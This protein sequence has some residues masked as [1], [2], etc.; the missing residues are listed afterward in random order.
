MAQ[1]LAGNA[2]G[3]FFVKPELEV[4][5]RIEWALPFGQKPSLPVG[6]L[7]AQLGDFLTPAPPRA[8]II[9]HHFNLADLAQFAVTDRILRGDL[10][11]LA[12]VLRAHLD[13][14]I[15]RPDGVA[16]GPRLIQ[17]SRHW[18]FD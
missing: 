6:V 3:K 17:L 5:P 15:A 10:V 7:L 9:P 2:A 8:V 16:R 11:G 1:P 14:Q 13:D 18:F 12:A 4:H